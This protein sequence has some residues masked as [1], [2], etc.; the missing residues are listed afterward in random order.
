MKPGII[1]EPNDIKEL[2]AKEYGVKP[3]D[4]IKI[5][6]SYIVVT[7]GKAEEADEVR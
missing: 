5:Q 6:Y 3:E 2:I 7:D 4:V 1:L